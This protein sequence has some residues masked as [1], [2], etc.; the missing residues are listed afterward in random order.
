[1]QG[2]PLESDRIEQEFLIGTKIH[3]NPAQLP[4]FW[5][6]EQSQSGAWRPSQTEH[7]L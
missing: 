5:P 3:Q 1:M 4:D 7:S 6:S 2:N